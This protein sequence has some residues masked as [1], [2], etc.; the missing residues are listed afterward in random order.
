M[1][2]IDNFVNLTNI[3]KTQFFNKILTNYFEGKVLNNNF[4]K[5]DEYF[6]F[7]IEELKENGIVKASSELP[8]ND[9]DK[10][11]I[12][13][14]IPNNLDTFNKENETYCYGKQTQHKG[15]YTLYNVYYNTDIKKDKLLQIEDIDEF[16]LIFKYDYSKKEL[17]ISLVNS[18]DLYLYV[19]SNSTIL[20]EVEESKNNFYNNISDS[21]FVNLVEL[22][23]TFE[24]IESF[25]IIKD[26]QIFS[27][28]EEFKRI[29][30]KID[31]LEKI[32]HNSKE[33]YFMHEKDLKEI[34][35]ETN[36]FNITSH[37]NRF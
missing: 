8:I 27:Q 28:S 23:K 20:K 21:G 15:I 37:K 24:V 10:C 6:Y 25:R 12:V 34:L 1:N 7:N 16:N 26:L 19:P 5:L 13:K 14:K 3:D 30:K 35:K 17:F 33:G 31:K 9:L 29:I 32:S 4:I 18:N 11:L 2:K 36:K 22:F